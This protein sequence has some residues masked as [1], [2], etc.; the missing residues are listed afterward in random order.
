MTL[1]VRIV[2]FD[3]GEKKMFM[4]SNQIVSSQKKQTM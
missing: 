2:W 3:Y 1:R 4:Q